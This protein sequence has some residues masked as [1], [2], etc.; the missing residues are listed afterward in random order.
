MTVCARG[1]EVL[2][3]THMCVQ[4]QAKPFSLH[5]TASSTSFNK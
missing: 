2:V 1:T 3:C 4:D 5:L